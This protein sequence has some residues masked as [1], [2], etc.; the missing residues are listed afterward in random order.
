[1]Y[2]VTQ[3][4]EAE[5]Y[6][7]YY[8]EDAYNGNKCFKQNITLQKIAFADKTR[9]KITKMKNVEEPLVCDGNH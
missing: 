3:N 4:T 1:M 2:P 5:I 8:A 9:W 7:Y 6:V